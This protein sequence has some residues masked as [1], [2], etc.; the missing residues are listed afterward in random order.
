MSLDGDGPWEL[1]I[2]GFEITDVTASV[3]W[4]EITMSAA[5]QNEFKIKL[6]GRFELRDPTG[7]GQG[8]GPRSP[9]ALSA[10]SALRGDLVRVAQITSRSDLHVEFASGHELDCVCD[11]P[12]ETWN[13][14]APDGI[15]VVSV[16]G[17]DAPAISAIDR[18]G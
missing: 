6:G 13:I 2:E 12:R 10:L 1:D 17:A 18:F 4:L 15:V 14:N 3:S 7:V 11:G 16:P 9:G 8:L 5:E